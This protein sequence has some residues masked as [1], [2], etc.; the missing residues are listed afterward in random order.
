MRYVMIAAL[1]LVGGATASS[2]QSTVETG[3]GTFSALPLGARNGV[4]VLGQSN[5]RLLAGPKLVEVAA[6]GTPPRFLGDNVAF[7]PN[8]AV[9]PRVFALA[10]DGDI[11]WVGLG[12]SD[13]AADAEEPPSTAAGF[14]LST[15]GGAT[16][17]ARF[18]ALDAPAATSVTYGVS[19][20]P[21]VPVT[22]PQGA[23]PISMSM[24]PGGD[25][26]YAATGLGGLRRTTDRGTSWTRIV[27]PPD[28]LLSLDP[29]QAYDFP[30]EPG[31]QRRADRSFPSAAANFVTYSVLVD[32]TGTVWAGSAYGLNRS[33]RVPGSADFGW[34]RY[35][36]NPLGGAPTANQIYT[37]A[38]RPGAPGTRSAVWIAAWNSGTPGIAEDEEFGVSVFRGDDADG[39]AQFETVLLG[40]R[41]YD[42]AFDAQNAFAASDDGLYI[43]ADDG[44]TWRVVRTFRD[45]SGRPLPLN[46]E[47]GVFSVEVVGSTIWAGTSDGLLRS[48]DGARTWTLFRA[49]VPTSPGPLPSTLDADAVPEVEVYAYPNP[50]TP[51]T[52]GSLRVRFDL[53]APAD[54]RVRVFDF[55]MRLVRELSAPGRPTGANEVLWDGLGDDGLRV[56]NGPYVYVVTAGD[57]TMSGRVLVFQ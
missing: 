19:T 15:D 20:L 38:E 52:D 4:F 5:G 22:A 54:V 24:T 1:I 46:D 13:V 28:S 17:Q 3:S 35:L 26:L 21:A 12:F 47:A 56:S 18:S 29:R 27:L 41:V 30:Y 8:T 31:Q 10:T 49:S 51:R 44:A 2:A 33:F 16:W 43:S 39:R 34:V 45:G 57:R 40:V 6:D 36:D 53:D 25:T 9:D 23:P 55:G 42:F 48:T 32:E 11:I 37:I 14:A 50:Y 7:D